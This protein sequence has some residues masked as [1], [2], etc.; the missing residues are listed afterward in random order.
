MNGTSVRPKCDVYIDLLCTVGLRT[1]VPLFV[2]LPPAFLPLQPSP[3]SGGGRQERLARYIDRG[4]VNHLG[5]AVYP[6]IASPPG[7]RARSLR[8]SIVRT[9]ACHTGMH[10]ATIESQ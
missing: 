3:V 6:S 10:A 9:G 1:W 5:L 4:I 7:G 8:F 2:P